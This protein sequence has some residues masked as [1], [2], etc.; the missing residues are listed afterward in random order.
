MTGAAPPGDHFTTVRDIARLI[1]ARGGRALLVGG[2][3]RDRLLGLESPDFDL[4][5]FGIQ[6]QDLIELLESFHPVDPTG[7]AFGVLKLKGLPI[8][9]SLPRRESKIGLGHRGFLVDADPFLPLEAAAA[10]RDFT[11]NAIAE[12]PLTGEVIDPFQGRRDLADRIMR[13]TSDQFGEDPLRV[14]RGMQFIARF[15]LTAAPETVRLCRGIGME[16]LAPERIF[17]EWRKLILTGETPALGL[18]FLRDTGWIDHFPELKALIGCPQDPRW[19]PEGDVWTHTL[20]CLDAFAEE[21][22]G[23]DREDLV[24]G[25]AVLCHDLGKPATT[26]IDP[27][28]IR[29]L[30]H[31]EAGEEPTRAF[32]GRMT[33]QLDLVEQVVPLVREHLRPEELHKA[34]AGDGAI[35]RLASRVGRIDRLV[36]VARADRRGRPPLEDDFPAGPWLLERA[37][38]LKVE[39][40]APRPLVQGRHLIALGRTP[41]PD[42]GPILDVCYEAQLDG[43]FTDEDGGLAYLRALLAGGTD[44]P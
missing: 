7:R 31:C 22:T 9:V 44:R 30:G 12:D 42:F 18:A 17:E 40:R 8:D 2:S 39:R 6:P 32:L 24:V 25:L 37:E 36:R 38:A 27:D 16:G 13:H 26:I 28:A 43:A 10:R 1:A 11:I 4:E 21:R 41:G 23:D 5:V 35:R 14:L 29:S 19:H 15:G 34:G 3:V 20:H 33:R